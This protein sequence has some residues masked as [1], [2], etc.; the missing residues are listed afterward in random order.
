[1]TE[2]I[3]GWGRNLPAEM[4]G[5]IAATWGARAIY[6]NRVIDLLPD[7]QS[8]HLDGFSEDDADPTSVEYENRRRALAPLSRWIDKK[9][10]PFLRRE[11]KQF[12]SPD[13]N[14]MVKLDDGNFHIEASPQ[15]SYGYLY[16]RAWESKS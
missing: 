13:S 8:W 14:E 7:R 15:A 1:M 9:G 12:L 5:R 6:T 11:A 4:K 2:I 3:Q 16:I 10:L